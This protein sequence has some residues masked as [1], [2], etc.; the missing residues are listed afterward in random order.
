MFFPSH[1]TDE[2]T[3]SEQLIQLFGVTQLVS[4]RAKCKPII[5]LQNRLCYLAAGGGEFVERGRKEKGNAGRARTILPQSDREGKMKGDSCPRSGR[6]SHL[7][8]CSPA[9]FLCPGTVLVPATLRRLDC[10]LLPKAEN[11][12]GRIWD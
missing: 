6:S 10:Q 12:G 3:E 4:A 8:S 11:C 7:Q 1:F 5:R 2:E 9:S